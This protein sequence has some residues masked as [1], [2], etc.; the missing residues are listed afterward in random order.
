MKKTIALILALALLLT[1]AIASADTFR[2]GI[3][4]DYPPFSYRDANGEFAGFDVDVCKAVCELLGW[5]YEAV[6][7][8]WGTKE[9]SLNANEIDCVWSG[10][11][12][13]PA[14]VKA[15]FVISA[16][17]YENKQVILTKE[18]SGIATKEDLAGKLVAVQAD[19]SADVMLSKS[20]DDEEFP[21]GML[22]LAQTFQG[23]EPVRMQNYLNC[24]TELDANGV[25][26][27]IVDLPV[28]YQ[29][30]AEH[31][32]F[33]V[34]DETL[35]NEQYGILFRAGDEEICKQ[36][37]DAIAQLVESGKYAELL[38]KE[39]ELDPQYFILLQAAE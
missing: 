24:A 29:L 31:Q 28:A 26:A 14:M 30:A 27:I 4:A 35:G 10:M 38:A 13:L 19:T 5:E 22:E 37:E 32:G 2:Q 15:G 39:K 34:L 21:G 17:Y 33:V 12:I 7:V 1:A 3:D 20:A 23:G 36:V 8:D 11:T 6:P 18:N 16:P 9:V 25:D